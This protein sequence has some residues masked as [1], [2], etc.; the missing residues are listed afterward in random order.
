MKQVILEIA[1]VTGMDIQEKDIPSRTTIER[2]QIEL[3]TISDLQVR[4]ELYTNICT[5]AYINIKII[6][7]SRKNNVIIFVYYRLQ[8]LSM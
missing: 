1:Q 4:I 6:H 7:Y 2:M 8:N 3:G 5:F